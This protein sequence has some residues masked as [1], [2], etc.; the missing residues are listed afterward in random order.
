MLTLEIDDRVSL[1]GI[2]VRIKAEPRDEQQ[3]ALV[4]VTDDPKAFV[5]SRVGGP[6][7][8]DRIGSLMDHVVIDWRQGKLLVEMTIADHQTRLRIFHR[9][10]HLYL[11]GLGLRQRCRAEG[12]RKSTR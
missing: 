2:E 1:R 9:H 7:Y 12:D 11:A 5:D 6:H 8:P 10:K 4:V 3:F